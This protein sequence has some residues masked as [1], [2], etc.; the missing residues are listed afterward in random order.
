MSD[1]RQRLGRLT[2]LTV[3]LSLLLAALVYRLLRRDL[4]ALEV[5]TEKRAI[6]AF[7]IHSEASHD[8]GVAV[9]TLVEA[10]RRI[11]LDFIVLTDHNNQLAA[12]I[13]LDGVTV[14]SSAEL[15]TPFGHVVQL[16]AVD[17]LPPAGRE[18]LEVHE[19]IRAL[20]GTPILAH[21]TDR[22]KPWTGLVKGAGGFEIAN[23]AS[24]V[25]RAGGLA[26]LGLLPVVPAYLLRPNLALSQFYDRDSKALYR[27]DSETDPRIVGLC[28]VDSHGWIE[29]GINLKAWQLVLHT[30]L[31][32]TESERPAVVLEHLRSGRFHCVA[33][34]FGTNPDF[35][36]G[37]RERGRWVAG[38]GESIAADVIDELLVL[39]P[40][41]RAPIGLELLRHGE[42]LIRVSGQ[43][44]RY[45]FP[46]PGT[47]RV[48]VRLQTPGL[49]FGNRYEPVLY[50]NRIR[51][52]PPMR[53]APPD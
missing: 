50:S 1:L 40:S 48:E 22:K 49:W 17:V 47:Y 7:H 27:W 10:A 9:K 38:P 15:S 23:L 11:G 42:P 36:F 41:S 26:F 31:P 8:S 12:P 39:G 24:S 25:R 43:R 2:A 19:A 21:P 30:T 5:S 6:G 35:V 32:K 46:A 16:G 44:L 34:L 53:S 20:D 14:L 3:V 4:P 33:G 45:P 29:S 37:A 13:V 28:G 52:L 51:V 18:K